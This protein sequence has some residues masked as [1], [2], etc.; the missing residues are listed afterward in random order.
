MRRLLV[1]LAVLLLSLPVAAQSVSEILTTIVD[2]IT[3]APYVVACDFGN[4]TTR[5]FALEAASVAGDYTIVQVCNVF[6][7]IR[8]PT[9]RYVNDPVGLNYIALASESIGI[10]FHGDCDDFAVLMASC[11]R[12]IGGACRIAIV[13]PAS[14]EGHAFAEVY[15]GDECSAESIQEYIE[16]RYG[17]SYVFFDQ[18]Q[19]TPG[20]YWL[21]LDWGG[22]QPTWSDAFPGHPPIVR[23]ATATKVLHA[24]VYDLSLPLTVPSVP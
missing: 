19:N 2:S 5:G 1:L 4:P 3:V 9:W 20:T 8:P 7:A 6:D 16:R 11:I 17:V 10:H 23:L 14:G 24:P 12:A 21:T 22:T 18:D 13:T 15:V